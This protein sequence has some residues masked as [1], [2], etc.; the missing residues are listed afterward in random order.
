MKYQD[1]EHFFS[2]K[3]M[4]RFFVACNGEKKK[5]VLLYRYNLRLAHEL[6]TTRWDET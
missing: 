3:R 1:Y 4:K 6:L 5:A 2:K